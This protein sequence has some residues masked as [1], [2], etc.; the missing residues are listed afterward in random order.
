M[1]VTDR[2]AGITAIDSSGLTRQRVSEQVMSV[3]RQAILD[4]RIAPGTSLREVALAEEL[5]VSRN[6]IRE[7][8]RA[9]ANEGLVRQLMHRGAVVAQ[10]TEDDVRDVY[11]AR[12][13]IETAAAGAVAEGEEPRL[14]P[15]ARA[16]AAMRA[17]VKKDSL[18]E[19]TDADLAFHRAIV[20]LAGSARL[21]AFYANLQS[22]L[23]LLLLIAD[24]EAP[25]A[26]KVADHERLLELVAAR[27]GPALSAA[28]A[29]HIEAAEAVHLRVAREQAAAGGA[30]AGGA[31][32]S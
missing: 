28:L 23:R 25:D 24:R 29:E 19:L 14:D 3:L 30:A 22:E 31:L 27:D 10:P 16:V 7:A 12:S 13:T 18:E 11:R 20:A 17:A 26:A 5:S 8:I 21:D 4:G 15:L 1:P 9:L 6:T 2:S 32:R